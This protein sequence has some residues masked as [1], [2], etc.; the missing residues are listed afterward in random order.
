MGMTEKQVEQLLG[1][2]KKKISVSL[3]NGKQGRFARYTSHGADF[4]VTY[5]AA[6]RVVSMETYS[7]FFKTAAGVGPGSPI[8]AAEAQK[9]FRPDYCELGYWNGGAHT[10]PGDP[11]TVFTPG[12]DH[13]AS[14]MV[15]QARYYTTCESGPGELS[16]A[17]A[18]V[19]AAADVVPN[20]SIAGVG[21]GMTEA[22]V[23]K[24]YG[25]PLSTVKL[26]LGG[27]QTGTFARY[28]EH[29]KPM[30]VTYDS[31]GHVAS[32]EAY[33]PS[34]KTAAGIGPG[35][36]LAQVQKLKGFGPDYCELG[37]WNGNAHTRP[38]DV[39]T[40]F[41]PSGGSVASVLITELRLYTACDTGSQAPPPS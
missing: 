3:G 38:T 1:K 14:V 4:L 40:V 32:I 41:T 9:G 23:V 11:V 18:A 29:G 36:S 22:Q 16:P 7:P 31:A 28:R 2:P 21:I 5:D 26:S 27:G 6:E 20:R 30:L 13:V 25:D 19:P 17:E 39:V 37:F 35:S 8:T 24:L 10:G 34:F 12:G 15:T 33:S